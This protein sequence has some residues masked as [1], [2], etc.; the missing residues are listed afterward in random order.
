[1]PSCVT[2]TDGHTDRT[3]PIIAFRNFANAPKIALTSVIRPGE[4]TTY[5]IKYWRNT[6]VLSLASQFVP[7]P[8]V[9]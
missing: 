6:V 8:E 4:C 2:R 9:P 1:M 5:D 7:H 3:K